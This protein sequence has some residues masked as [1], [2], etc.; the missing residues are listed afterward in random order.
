MVKK[1]IALT[2]Y[3]TAH[4]AAQLLSLKH[5]RPIHPKYIRKLADRKKN[6]VRV[7]RVGDRLLYHKQDIESI[8]IR[9]KSTKKSC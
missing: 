3:I 2:D 5:G 1:I 8:T 4:H 6:S 7:Q 9:Q